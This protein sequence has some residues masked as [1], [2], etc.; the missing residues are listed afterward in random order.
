MNFELQWWVKVKAVGCFMNA[1]LRLQLIH[2]KGLI[3][4][5][6]YSVFIRDISVSRL[7]GD[8]IWLYLSPVQ[9]KPMCG[10][11]TCCISVQ[12][13]YRNLKFDIDQLI[14]LAPGLLGFVTF[15]SLACTIYYTKL[16]CL[17][18]IHTSKYCLTV[19]FFFSILKCKT[20][21]SQHYIGYFPVRRVHMVSVVLVQNG[22][23]ILDH[24][25]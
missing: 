14:L 24:L 8:V 2:A 7:E 5:K 13:A 19:A 25:L 21:L 15:I 23:A 16:F 11:R 6:V 9:G 17:Q 18:I 22:S 4:T 10:S 3:R 20:T 12:S 1:S